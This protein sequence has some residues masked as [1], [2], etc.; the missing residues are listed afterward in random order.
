MRAFVHE[1]LPGRVVFGEGSVACLPEE[2]DRLGVRRALVLST[3]GRR[4]LAAELAARLGARVVGIFDGAM[5]H[6]PAEVA[7]RARR[8]AAEARADGCLA[9]GGGSTIGLGKAIAL[10]PGLPLA[11][12]PTTFSGSEA[13]PIYGVTEGG[14]KRTGRH[15]RVLPR[16]IIYDPVVARSLPATVAGPSG[17]NAIAH[18]VEALYARDGSPVVSLLAEE[19]IRVLAAALP[20][21]VADQD[22]LEAMGD[23]LYGAWLAGACLG[24]AGMALH[25]KLCHTL[26]G[27]FGLPHAE[28]HAVLLPHVAAYNAPATPETMARVARALGAADAAG[29]LFD[30]GRALGVPASLAEIGMPAAALERASRLATESPY[31]NPRPVD[32][33]AVLALLADAHAG[34]RPT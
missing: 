29:A 3:P 4:V 23:A 27:S 20:R 17:L 12:I 31:W 22:G 10:D 21:L 32:R 11:A 26:G 6:V 7:E 30:L 14:I 18:C 33:E 28:T 9:I 15:V 34:R 13:T 16:L 2:L 5:V 19:G 24:A 1:A 25:H 8:A